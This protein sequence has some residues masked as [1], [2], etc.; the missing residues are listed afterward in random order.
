LRLHYRSLGSTNDLARELARA[1]YPHG[2]VVIADYQT[3]GRGRQ[4][5]RWEAQPG[6]ALLC[7]TLLRPELPAS[8]LPSLAMA[9]AL[10]TADAVAAV[11][12]RPAALK[13]PNDVMASEA[14]G[15]SLRKVAGILAETAFAGER[16]EFVVLGVG[17]NVSGHPPDLPTATDL[18]RVAGQGVARSA[19]LDALM[20][21]L[22]ARLGSL[23]QGE[24][25][26]ARA[27]RAIFDAWRARLTTLGR[28]VRVATAA[29]E[30]DAVA[31]TV[32]PDGALVVRTAS[33]ERRRLL[34][35]DA[36]LS[37]GRTA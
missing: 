3:A 36:T 13:W 21:N 25:D 22:D 11:T 37:H 23:S 29:D 17:M 35:A 9:A 31:E 6:A 26:G 30:F 18:A 34:A 4:G 12:G 33:G 8:A 10:A 19:A 28:P 16:V 27:A 2:A 14:G 24:R 20:A 7:S 15:G 1:G 5:R 32:E